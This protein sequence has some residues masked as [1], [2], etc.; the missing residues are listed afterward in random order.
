M[1]LVGFSTLR[2]AVEA[3]L[4]GEAV[5]RFGLEILGAGIQSRASNYTPF[6]EVAREALPCPADVPC[7]TSL[8]LAL[9]HRPGALGEVLQELSRRGVSLS[10]IESRPQPLTRWRYRFYLDLEGHAASAPVAEALEAI[11]PF[12]AELRVLGTYPAAERPG[13]LSSPSSPPARNDS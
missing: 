5:R 6:F 4:D 13:E 9:V 7:K 2:E 1:L 11:A 12:A 8:L 3:V 10:K